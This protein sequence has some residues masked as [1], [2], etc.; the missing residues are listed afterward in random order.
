MY[1]DAYIYIY[2][3]ITD[4]RSPRPT[5]VACWVGGSSPNS[6]P[7]KQAGPYG[8]VRGQRMAATYPSRLVAMVTGKD[9]PHQM[10][11]YFMY[12]LVV[13]TR[14]MSS[15]LLNSRNTPP[16]PRKHGR[17]DPKRTQGH[18]LQVQKLCI[19][20]KRFRHEPFVINA[21]CLLY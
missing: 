7:T 3:Y 4:H 8:R 11:R 17:R 9:H 21:G 12:G 6:H 5:V 15:N 14:K 16:A 18:T 10:R 19:Y 20:G 2:I 1:V 13:H